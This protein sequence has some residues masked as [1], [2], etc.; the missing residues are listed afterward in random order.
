M[1]YKSYSKYFFL[2]QIKH[3]DLKELFSMYKVINPFCIILFL[4]GDASAPLPEVC[5][6]PGG[7]GLRREILR[8]SQTDKPKVRLRYMVFEKIKS[9]TKT[10]VEYYVP[11]EQTNPK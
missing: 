5:S 3:F 6:Q 8:P 1:S 10:T 2:L 9:L 11:H 4:E 7:Q